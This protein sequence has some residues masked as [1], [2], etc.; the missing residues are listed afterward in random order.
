M[1]FGRPESFITR[2]KRELKRMP[3]TYG[4]LIA[5]VVV[6]IVEYIFPQTIILFGLIPFEFV[7]GHY[8]TL[9]THIFIHSLYI[10]H[11]LFNAIALYYIGRYVESLIGSRLMIVVFFITGISG[12]ILTIL[13]SFLLPYINPLSSHLANSIYIGASGAIL[14]LFSFFVSDNPNAEFIF[15]IFLPFPIIIPIRARGRTLLI[16]LLITELFFGI[17]SLPFDFYGRWGHLGGLIS[18]ILLYRYWLWKEVYKRAYGVEF[19]R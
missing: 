19:Y 1:Y 3:A 8:W 6:Q 5:L 7:L 18:G 17:L 15:F 13:A 4:L 14:G 9:F 10:T 2:F 12:G 11:L 16:I